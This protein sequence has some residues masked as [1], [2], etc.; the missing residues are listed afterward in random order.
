MTVNNPANP[1]VTLPLRGM[2]SATCLVAAPT[3]VDFGPIRYD[4]ATS[5]RRT[6]ISNQCPRPITVTDAQHR[7]RHQRPV[8]RSPRR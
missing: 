8:S 7:H 2:S 3:F 4:C 6:L 1:T 5:P